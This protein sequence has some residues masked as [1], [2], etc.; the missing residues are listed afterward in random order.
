MSSSLDFCVKHWHLPLSL[1]PAWAARGYT[2][3]LTSCCRALAVQRPRVRTWQRCAWVAGLRPNRTTALR[4]IHGELDEDCRL[5]ALMEFC[6]RYFALSTALSATRPLSLWSLQVPFRLSL[7]NVT[8][9]RSLREGRLKV[10]RIRTFADRGVVVIQETHLL[11]NDPLP[12]GQQLPH[13]TVH[14]SM[15]VPTDH[16]GTSGGLMFIVPEHLGYKAVST[17]HEVIPGFLAWILVD[18]LG[19]C[20]RCWN[21]Y[22]VPHRR[23]FVLDA[24]HTECQRIAEADVSDDCLDALDVFAGD[25]NASPFREADAGALATADKALRL[26]F[27]RF[28]TLADAQIQGTYRDVHGPHWIDHAGGTAASEGRVSLNWHLCRALDVTVSGQHVPLILTGSLG[29]QHGYTRRRFPPLPLY[30]FLGRGAACNELVRRLTRCMTDSGVP[31]DVVRAKRRAFTDTAGT[32]GD[33]ALLGVA[34][35][36][37]DACRLSHTPLTYFSQMEVIVHDWARGELRA[38]RKSAEEVVQDAM[39]VGGEVRVPV[40]AWCALHCALDMQPSGRRD[41]DVYVID[42]GQCQAV[43]HAYR[44]LTLD[45]AG[46]QQHTDAIT[47]EQRRRYR[48]LFPKV[49]RFDE[50]LESAAGLVGDPQEL[51]RLYAESRDFW[52]RSPD[53]DHAVQAGHLQQYVDY[54]V[55]DRKLDVRLPALPEIHFVVVNAPDSSPGYRGVPFA[56]WRMVSLGVAMLLR[57][58]LVELLRDGAAALDHSPLRH[59][60]TKWIPKKKEGHRAADRR[61]LGISASFY[62]LVNALL[63]RIFM[64]HMRPRMHPAQ[65]LF[66]Q[67]GEALAAV[68]RMQAYLDTGQV[69]PH[70]VPFETCP[71]AA[72][73]A[74]EALV[75][76]WYQSNVAPATQ[77]DSLRTVSLSD[78]NKA[79]ERISPTWIMQVLCAWGVPLWLATLAAFFLYDRLVHLYVSGWVGPGR[80]VYSGVDMGGNASPDLYCLGID[81]LLWLLVLLPDI[82]QVEG[83]MDDLAAAGGLCG[84]AW[85]QAAL[86]SFSVA[87]PFVIDYHTCWEVNDGA[88]WLRCGTPVANYTEQ[89]SHVREVRS[90]RGAVY[91]GTGPELAE[92]CCHLRPECTC[93][94]KLQIVPHRRPSRAEC[95][96]LL[97]MQWGTACLTEHAEYLGV[98]LG[99]HVLWT[100]PQPANVHIHRA[101]LSFAKPLRRM[102]ERVDLLAGVQQSATQRSLTWTVYILP[103]LSYV[104]QYCW[105]HAPVHGQVVRLLTRHLRCSW[106][107][108]A[109]HLQCMRVWSGKS[110]APQSVSAVCAGYYVSSWCRQHRDQW[111]FTL[112]VSSGGDLACDAVL[113]SIR[114]GSDA[115]CSRKASKVLQVLGETPSSAPRQFVGRTV[116]TALDEKHA[117]EHETEMLR[118]FLRWPLAT[119]PPL[120]CHAYKGARHSFQHIFTMFRWLCNAIPTER[121]RRHW[122]RAGLPPLRCAICSCEANVL[123]VTT[124]GEIGVCYEHLME[125]ALDRFEGSGWRAFAALVAAVGQDRLEGVDPESALSHD[126]ARVLCRAASGDGRLATVSSNCAGCGLSDDSL[127]HRLFACPVVGAAWEV[128]FGEAEVVWTG[129]AA[130]PS[131]LLSFFQA[132]HLWFAARAHVDSMRVTKSSAA[133]H[134]NSQSLLQSWWDS[135][136]PAEKAWDVARRLLQHGVRLNARRW[137]AAVAVSFGVFSSKDLCA[138][139]AVSR[140]ALAVTHAVQQIAEGTPAPCEECLEFW[141]SASADSIVS[142]RVGPGLVLAAGC[143][144]YRA[145]RWAVSR[146][147]DAGCLF[148]AWLS[149]PIG[150]CYSAAMR[151][152]VLPRNVRLGCDYTVQVATDRCSC[153]WDRHGVHASRELAAGTELVSLHRATWQG[154][155]CRLV[156][157]FD[158]GGKWISDR[159][160]F[161][162][163]LVAFLYQGG[164]A[165]KLAELALPLYDAESAQEAEAAAGWEA[166]MWREQ[167]LRFAIDRGFQP[168][169][170]DVLYG[171]SANTVGATEGRVRLRAQGPIRW[172]AGMREVAAT[173]TRGWTMV[174]V[175]RSM[176]KAADAVATT[177]WQLTRDVRSAAPQ[178]VRSGTSWPLPTEGVALIDAS[179]W[180]QVLFVFARSLGTGAD[181]EKLPWRLRLAE[182]FQRSSYSCAGPTTLVDPLPQLEWSLCSPDW[183]HETL[184]YAL[185][186]MPTQSNRTGQRFYRAWKLQQ[187][188]D[189]ANGLMGSTWVFTWHATPDE[190]GQGRAQERTPG[191]Q[192]IPRPLRALLLHLRHREYDL[193]S[194]HLV[195]LASVV[196]AAEAPVLHHVLHELA[197]D[198]A[199]TFLKPLP[200]GKRSLIAPLNCGDL[201]APSGDMQLWMR[202]QTSV[203]HVSGLLGVAGKFNGDYAYQARGRYAHPAGA[204]LACRHGYWELRCDDHGPC[205]RI[206]SHG[207]TSPPLGLWDAVRPQMGSMRLSQRAR[208][209]PHW[210]EDYVTE[211]HHVIPLAIGRLEQRGYTGLVGQTERNYVYHHTAHVEARVV[212]LVLHML[213]ASRP[214]FSHALVHDAL[215]VDNR[216]PAAD[217]LIAFET[218]AAALELPMLRA[219]EKVWTPDLQQARFNLQSAGYAPNATIPCDA[220]DAYDE[221]STLYRF[222]ARPLFDAQRIVP[223]T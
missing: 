212:R 81:P 100:T 139:S 58:F 29:N 198:R 82:A 126:V 218:V 206:A 24:F 68:R 145:Q 110:I 160:C 114:W 177:A 138:L 209:L 124:L 146:H 107:L 192:M 26:R 155:Q 18:Y 103:L 128:A 164:V 143:H 199:K 172:T 141:S 72:Q 182:R 171:D 53:C 185:V 34:E 12:I 207:G 175:P 205:F 119:L 117:A 36:L 90:P 52:F 54:V 111:W 222:A 97:S 157:T 20:F 62:R 40:D 70:E 89:S 223:R 65:A 184:Y 86:R 2:G 59:Q 144:D 132:V 194:C 214:L 63:H 61:P 181:L 188:F 23:K 162:A 148:Y 67:Q 147:T 153:G 33:Q 159:P 55:R 43:L 154:D 91:C 165:H 115:R 78:F 47:P 130:M 69:T 3:Y 30:L 140:A 150:G 166:V 45:I 28:C 151:P 120:S 170:P 215:L 79:F 211:L 131:S 122:V 134:R 92:L 1:F 129:R 105:L 51:D 201:L 191:V 190:S 56:A 202:A 38:R 106:W 50:R 98:M 210:Y 27:A 7:W 137:S 95:H 108:S 167:A 125:L 196:T 15:A 200:G 94:C 5:P 213:R 93:S 121:R 217:V 180:V 112:H 13:C 46:P 4:H 11:A 156:V 41:R 80:R 118:R 221:A 116:R 135:L 22:A 168:S 189:L 39:R 219:V 35:G 66:R 84:A 163:G 102:E 133:W 75:R 17:V 169:P 216:I 197:P 19:L 176:N 9:L 44:T 173:Q 161:G 88:G 31:L 204:T 14:Y 136:L 83:Y 49:K 37:A 74:A 193:A 183:S 101:Q 21:V 123:P 73:L 64:A 203:H 8:S 152:A 57:C 10:D 195:A 142:V 127:E 104:A 186:F 16:G 208:R 25:L 85:F 42:R 99:A 60:L 32:T 149:H 76:P 87:V 187:A 48:K 96:H 71:P 77:P 174:D 113:E 179:A 220:E 109:A 178:L 6:E 158:G